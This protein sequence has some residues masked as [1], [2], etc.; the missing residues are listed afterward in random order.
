MSKQNPV[1]ASILSAFALVALF[2]FTVV[3]HVE[4]GAPIGG[5][6]IKLGKNPGG[7]G[8]ARTTTDGAGHFSFPAQPAGSYTITV[9]STEPAEITVKG[10]V[11]GTIK[12]SSSST[13]S[14]AKATAAPLKVDLKSDGKTAITGKLIKIAAGTEA[15]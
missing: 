8:V 9:V 12:K 13:Q 11:G 5:I 7:G 15:Y 14:A 3:S 4:A 1:P 2:L 6:D 10:A